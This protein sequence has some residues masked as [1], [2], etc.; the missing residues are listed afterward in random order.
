VTVISYQLWKGHFKNDPQIIGKTQR[1]SGTLHTIVGVMPEGFYGTF[2]G[3]AMQFWVPAS[4]EETFEAG[5]YKLEDR[6]ARWIEAYVRRPASVSDK[7]RR[8][9]RRGGPIG[10]RL[11]GYQPRPRDQTLAVVANAVQ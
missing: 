3:W 5:G 10:I 8:K 1:L 11:S 7:R 6:G 4:M 2:V 9:L